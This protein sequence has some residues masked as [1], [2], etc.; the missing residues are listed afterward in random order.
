VDW[1]DLEGALQASRPSVL[2][3]LQTRL[4][5]VS[6][7]SLAGLDDVIAQLRA[8]VVMPFVER[9]CLPMGQS[10]KEEYL[11]LLSLFFF[12]FNGTVLLIGSSGGV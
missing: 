9:V 12:S 7:A 1:Q 2:S 10:S 8:A 3:S 11:I 5:P 6:F 4:R